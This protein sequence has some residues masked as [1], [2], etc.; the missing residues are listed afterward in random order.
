[1]RFILWKL[2]TQEHVKQNRNYSSRK[3]ARMH[4]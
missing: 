3:K 2:R 1:M 4:I